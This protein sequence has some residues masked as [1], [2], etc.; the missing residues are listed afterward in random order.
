M[1]LQ[2]FTENTLS[3]VGKY[4]KS[5]ASLSAAS[6]FCWSPF[7]SIWVR[8][9]WMMCRYSRGRNGTKKSTMLF[10]IKLEFQKP[11]A[12]RIVR[13]FKQ[14]VKILGFLWNVNLCDHPYKNIYLLMLL[15]NTVTAI[16]L[17]K[18]LSSISSRSWPSLQNFKAVCVMTSFPALLERLKQH[19][20][21]L[22]SDCYDCLHL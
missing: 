5:L 11:P 4:S 1:V 7:A 9:H 21:L 20:R 16:S 2:P 17:S 8:T 19:V 12:E 10:L 15:L 13:T 14:A 3:N 22:D 6:R 18:S